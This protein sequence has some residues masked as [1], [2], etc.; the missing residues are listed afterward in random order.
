MKG[1]KP[2]PN[3][4][5]NHTPTTTNK[6]LPKKTG[7]ARG[8]V[9]KIVEICSFTMMMT[10]L[11]LASTTV[12]WQA[13]TPISIEHGFDLLTHAGR[14]KAETYLRKEK[15]DL[16][17][18]EWMCDPFSSMQNINL[19]KGGLTAEKILEK[20]SDSFQAH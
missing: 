9:R 4:D 1:N 8:P 15:P 3:V 17:V 20:T 5:Q 6:E 12:N 19:A 18:A 13:M 2:K 14:Q 7:L 11:A 10:A 16:I